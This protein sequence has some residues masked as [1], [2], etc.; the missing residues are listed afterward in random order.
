MLLLANRHVVYAGRIEREMQIISL[1]THMHPT[2]FD[3][4]VIDYTE[5]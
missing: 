3:F 1:E 2:L 4:R 5:R